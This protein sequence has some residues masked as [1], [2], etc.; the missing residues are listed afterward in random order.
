[1]RKAAS[2][3]PGDVAIKKEL[4][5]VMLERKRQNQKQAK[6]FKG[7]FDKIDLYDEKDNLDSKKV[8]LDEEAEGEEKEEDKEAL[9]EDTPVVAPE[10][11]E[12]SEV[13]RPD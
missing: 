13:G 10:E 11:N 5:K 2:L 8:K 4:Q 9:K 1:L 3:A 6:T 7:F 12:H